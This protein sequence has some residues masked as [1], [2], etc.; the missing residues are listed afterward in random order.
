MMSEPDKDLHGRQSRMS[1][2]MGRWE[3]VLSPKLA[4]IGY[5]APKNLRWLDGCWRKSAFNEE[6]IAR[7]APAT[8]TAIDRP[9]IKPRLCADHGPAEG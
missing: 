6:L 1:G 2:L 3:A 5:N 7:C 4:W 8:G 9:M